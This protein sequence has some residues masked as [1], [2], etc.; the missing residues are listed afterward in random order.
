MQALHN[1]SLS[2]TLSRPGVN[3]TLQQNRTFFYIFKVQ[4][5]S[6]GSFCS[7]R[8]Q[9]RTAITHTS[10]PGFQ[11]CNTTHVHIHHTHAHTHHTQT[12]MH[13]HTHTHTHTELNIVHASNTA[14]R[15]PAL[16]SEQYLVCLTQEPTHRQLCIHTCA[17][18][19]PKTPQNNQIHSCQ[20]G[21]HQPEV[22]FWKRENG[23]SFSTHGFK[24]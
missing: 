16:S 21:N 8:R 18:I 23:E 20:R 17:A 7:K 15:N 1:S 12:H 13:S 22:Y 6:R 5:N 2:S 11:H 19:R 9:K 10:P 24:S 3:L 4:T 14:R